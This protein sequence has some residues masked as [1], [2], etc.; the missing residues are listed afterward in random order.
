[1]IQGETISSGASP[2]CTTCKTKFEYEVLHTPAGYY[3]G[4]ACH[5]DGCADQ[6]PNTR[7]SGY[8]KTRKEAED[9]LKSGKFER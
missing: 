1:M 8:Y 5:N 3:I 7:D 6:G 2:V 9:A 4:T